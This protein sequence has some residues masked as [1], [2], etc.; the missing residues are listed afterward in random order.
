MADNE[1]S[2]FGRGL[3]SYV[4]SKLPY[5]QSYDMIDDIAR[6]N[7]KYKEFYKTGTRRDELLTYHS[8]STNRQG[9]DGNP[10]ASV[11]IDKNYHAFMY[12]NVDYDKSKR[13]RDYRVM[14][15]FS[16]VADALDEICDECIN[17]DDKDRIIRLEFAPQREYDTGVKKEIREEFEKF[18]RYYDLEN[19]GWEYCRW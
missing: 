14:A 16:E 19:K 3:M 9:A 12:A 4:A 17:K 13:L 10:M 7:P 1:G 15:Q 5:S 6:V 11:A 8:I 18:I 2:T